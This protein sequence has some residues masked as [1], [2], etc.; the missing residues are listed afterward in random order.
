MGRFP[1]LGCARRRENARLRIA[2][3]AKGMA[4]ARY[5]TRPRRPGPEQRS[6]PTCMGPQRW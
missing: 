5:R 2:A 3:A 6:P 4:P 1:G